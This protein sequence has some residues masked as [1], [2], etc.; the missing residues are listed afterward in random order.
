MINSFQSDFVF[1][2]QGNKYQEF[3]DMLNQCDTTDALKQ[4]IN[5]DAA[6]AKFER[7]RTEMLDVGD[8][9]SDD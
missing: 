7:M 6:I 3:I 2:L 4:Y 1:G 8:D 5:Y 9:D